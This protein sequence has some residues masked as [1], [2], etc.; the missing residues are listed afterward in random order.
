[1]LNFGKVTLPNMG[2]GLHVGGPTTPFLC[3]KVL[4]LLHV[5]CLESNVQTYYPKMEVFFMVCFTM[6]EYV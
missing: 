1:M 4:D 2:L 6:G 3:Q 5:R